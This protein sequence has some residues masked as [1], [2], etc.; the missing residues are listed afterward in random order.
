MSTYINDLA[1]ADHGAQAT[2]A[3]TESFAVGECAFDATVTE[4]EIIPSGALTASDATNRT[5]TLRN[6]GA[7]G[8]GTTVIATLT[9]NLAGG[10]WVANDAIL[11]ALS[12]TP[13]NL[14]VAAGDVL[15]VDETVA[16]TG[17][18]HPAMQVTVRGTRR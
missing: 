12:G 9:T 4:A 7:T 8:A 15:A 17:V 2:P 5:F 10:S 11:M 14:N 3:T 6:K 18:A 13:G 1:Q 16:S